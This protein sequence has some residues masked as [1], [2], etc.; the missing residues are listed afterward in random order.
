LESFLFTLD[1]FFVFLLSLAVVKR[2]KKKS[3]APDLGIFAY[4][5]KKIL[6][7]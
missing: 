4:S 7:K 2:S 6:L 5:A 1:V 3:P